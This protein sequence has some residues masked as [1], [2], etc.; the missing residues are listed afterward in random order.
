MLQQNRLR[1]GANNFVCS[2]IFEG[3][4][5][6]FTDGCFG[7]GQQRETKEFLR[8][9]MTWNIQ[10]DGTINKRTRERGK[11]FVWPS[12]VLSCWTEQSW[13]QTRAD[14]AVR[15]PQS[16]QTLS[17]VSH[18]VTFVIWASILPLS[19]TR[20]TNTQANDQYKV[21]GTFSGPRCTSLTLSIMQSAC[22]QSTVG[23]CKVVNFLCD[24]SIDHSSAFPLVT[25]W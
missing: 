16:T 8:L 1:V 6:N 22:I 17:P 11:G 13:F 10:D 20:R 23:R 7:A 4:N 15:R 5:K 9:I 3:S 18:S 14:R 24:S 21:L 2:N 12:D 25:E 19:T